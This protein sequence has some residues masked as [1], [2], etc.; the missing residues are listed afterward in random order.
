MEII[1]P[2]KPIKKRIN[3]IVKNGGSN[4]TSGGMDRFAFEKA[5]VVLDKFVA[6]TG[7]HLVRRAYNQFKWLVHGL[8]YLDHSDGKNTMDECLSFA[9]EDAQIAFTGY[10][11]E[12]MT[13]AVMALWSNLDTDLWDAFQNSVEKAFREAEQAT[14]STVKRRYLSRYRSRPVR[15]LDEGF[16]L[17]CVVPMFGTAVR[18]WAADVGEDPDDV[19]ER[20]MWIEQASKSLIEDHQNEKQDVR[21]DNKAYLTLIS[22]DDTIN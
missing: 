3:G 16:D 2:K 8:A 12:I 22:N 7:S 10:G 17:P 11:S 14:S 13:G 6:Q 18:D 21:T 9:W 4:D 5:Q 15:R 20:I 1:M 19:T